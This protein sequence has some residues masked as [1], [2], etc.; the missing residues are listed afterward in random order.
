MLNNNKATCYGPGFF[1]IAYVTNNLDKA[2]LD[3]SKQYGIHSF[4]TMKVLQFDENT[5]TNIATAYIGDTMIEI[6]EPTGTGEDIYS[7]MLPTTTEYAIRHHHFGHLFTNADDW[8]QQQN[9]LATLEKSIV[10]RGGLEGIVEAIYTD[11]RGTLGHYLEYIYCT[12]A[13]LDFLNMRNI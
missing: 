13:G 4:Y 6:I 12:P 11:E 2:K 10:Y 5:T 3:F 1:Q 8:Q 9:N 7:S